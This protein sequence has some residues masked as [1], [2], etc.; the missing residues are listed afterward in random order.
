VL[1]DW[2]GHDTTPPI[3]IMALWPFSDGFYQSSLFVFDAI[4][5]RY[6]QAD[7]YTRNTLAAIREL[8]ILAPLCA[9]VA[10]VRR[11]R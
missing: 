3:G 10:V 4:S 2:L 6:W 7:F 8:A 1:L 11:R 9:L 5:R